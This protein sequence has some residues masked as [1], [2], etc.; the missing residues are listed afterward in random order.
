MSLFRLVRLL[1][2]KLER[3]EIQM[4]EQRLNEIHKGNGESNGFLFSIA[5][6]QQKHLSFGNGLIRRYSVKKPLIFADSR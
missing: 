2:A 1:S 5:W 4:G 3:V 6:L